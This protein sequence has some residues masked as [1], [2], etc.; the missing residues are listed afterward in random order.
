MVSLV[1]R[2]FF[3]TAGA[4]TDAGSS[5]GRGVVIGRCG[6]FLPGP[7][8]ATG[9]D[10]RRRVTASLGPGP[11]PPALPVRGAS[12][13]AARRFSGGAIAPPSWPGQPWSL[14]RS[15][16]WC[17]PWSRRSSALAGRPSAGS[18]TGSAGLR[19]RLDLPGTDPAR[20]GRSRAPATATAWGVTSTT[21][22][23][24]R[25]GRAGLVRTGVDGTPAGSS[26]TGGSRSTA[27]GAM[28]TARRSTFRTPESDASR[29]R[30]ARSKAGE[31]PPTGRCARSR[32]AWA[33][34]SAAVSR[35][36]AD[37][38][39]EWRGSSRPPRG[40]L[41]QALTRPRPSAAAWRPRRLVRLH[42]ATV[43]RWVEPTSRSRTS[44]EA[45][46]EARS[47][48]M[49]GQQ[50]AGGDR[51]EHGD[52]QAP[53]T[54]RQVG[55]S[56]R[57]DRRRSARLRATDR[58]TSSGRSRSPGA[59]RVRNPVQT[60]RRRA[61]TR[62]REVLTDQHGARPRGRRAHGDG[63]G[64][65]IQTRMKTSPGRSSATMGTS[66][67][68]ASR[69]RRP[70]AVRPGRRRLLSARLLRSLSRGN[71]GSRI[72]RTMSCTGR[73]WHDRRSARRSSQPPGDQA[74][75]VATRAANTI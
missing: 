38:A 72:G 8:A 34:A 63:T 36:R 55:L 22:R 73:A 71:H 74:K 30:R 46:V 29:E 67:I 12:S 11:G 24:G 65:G 10:F 53:A 1:R 26:P 58:M 42:G 15:I 68:A 19:A 57:D 37:R 54:T 20:T 17:E 60:G 64:S 33:A 43:E 13:T 5:L 41:G 6:A 49:G 28:S 31:P 59:G 44:I 70:T 56:G 69:F 9:T 32:I 39:R 14:P 7:G 23:A 18:A 45:A 4:A 61:R 3:A 21:R 50:R 48:S 62:S 47:P 40:D 75:R 52:G 16:P 2:V 51:K 66:V 25:T 35:C 27:R